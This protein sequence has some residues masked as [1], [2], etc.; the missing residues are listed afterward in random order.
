MSSVSFM[1]P[2]AIMIFL[3]SCYQKWIKLLYMYMY[4]INEGSAYQYQK[5]V[6]NVQCTAMIIGQR[7]K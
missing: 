2:F 5:F 4:I 6:F 7:H 3:I 1:L